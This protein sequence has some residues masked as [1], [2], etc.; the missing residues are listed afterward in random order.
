MTA[1][2]LGEVYLLIKKLEKDKILDKSEVGKALNRLVIVAH[3]SHILISY[4]HNY[5]I[6]DNKVYEVKQ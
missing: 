5:C 6:V 3:E 1:T 2:E 4:R